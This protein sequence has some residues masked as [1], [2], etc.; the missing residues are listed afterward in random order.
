MG[1]KVTKI[2]LMRIDNEQVQE[3]EVT[4]AERLLR[5]RNNGGWVLPEKSNYQFDKENGITS[6][7]HQKGTNEDNQESND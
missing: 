3:F 4:H 2:A 6:K 1:A 5:M 7:R